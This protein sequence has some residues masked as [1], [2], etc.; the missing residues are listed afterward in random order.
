MANTAEYSREWY[1]KNREKALEYQRSYRERNKDKQKEYNKR[2]YEKRKKRH[3]VDLNFRLSTRLRNRLGRAIKGN[4]KSGSAVRDLGC[5]VEQFKLYLESK[6]EHG[7]NWDNW[8]RT[9]W[10]IDHIVPLSKFNLT[11]PEQLQK[12]CHYTNMQPLWVK[13][14]KRKTAE[15]LK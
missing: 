14:H 9:G 11:D 5:S 4:Y 13:D 12:A 15:D 2:S 8:S 6:F 1:S 7:M 3:S 10:H